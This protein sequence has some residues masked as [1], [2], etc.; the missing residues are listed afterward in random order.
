MKIMTYNANGLRSAADKG[1]FD[2]FGK[3]KTDVLC[4]QEC[5][6]AEDQ[7]ADKAFRPRGY[8]RWFNEAKT[9]KGYSGVGIYAR[10]EPDEVRTALGWSDFDDEGRYIEA[11]F[12]K[13]SV[14]SLYLPSGSSKEER[15]QFK[16]KVMDWIEP[17]F[18]GWRDEGREY[19]ICG[20][21]N[22]AHTP[23]D[24]KNAKSN[25]KNS[26]F[27]PAERDWLTRLFS[28]HGFVDSYRHLHPEGQ[29]YTWWSQRGAARAKN[30]GW[31]IDYQVVS[32]NLRERLKA[33][34]ITPEPRFSDHAPYAVE[35]HS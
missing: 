31:R 1:F 21:W 33:C 3:Q 19:V 34:A 12:G 24:I 7:L 22:I 4:L 30:V 11:R 6:A 27:L 29:D 20:D 32:P 13:L 17:I 25:A 2:W 14:V 35:F 23:M 8:K 15:Q 26:G 28:E 18:T 16:F 5:R 10:Q 9:K